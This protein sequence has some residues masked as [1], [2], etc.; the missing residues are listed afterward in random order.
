MNLTLH[1]LR[2]GLKRTKGLENLSAGW[3]ICPRVVIMAFLCPLQSGNNR[4]SSERHA[5]PTG[6][7]FPGCCH[8]S[9]PGSEVVADTCVQGST[10][11][12]KES[13][14]TYLPS[15]NFPQLKRIQ[16]SKLSPSP[17]THV[18]S[19]KPCLGLIPDVVFFM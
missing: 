3:R 16:G 15:S 7:T 10:V 1:W 18:Q 6:T 12:T 19:E 4:N 11:R 5:L 9:C 13:T 14:D 2:L 8:H 17:L